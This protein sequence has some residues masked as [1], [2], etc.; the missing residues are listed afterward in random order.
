MIREKLLQ[1]HSIYSV[2]TL[3][4]YLLTL[5]FSRLT[6]FLIELDKS[7]NDFSLP[8]IGYNIVNGYHIHHFVYGILILVAVAFVAIFIKVAKH[9]LPLYLFFGLALGLLFDEFGIWLKLDPKYDQAISVTAA[10]TVGFILLVI[11]LASF[12]FPNQFDEF[13]KAKVIKRLK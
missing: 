4:S 9:T 1:R 6:V 12:K 3:I 5:L 11:V 7:R 2:F 13:H 10:T 8:L